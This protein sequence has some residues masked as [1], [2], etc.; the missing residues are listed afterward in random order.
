MHIDIFDEIEY[1]AFD[2]FRYQFLK[3]DVAGDAIKGFTKVHKTGLQFFTFFV[4]IIFDKIM[5]YKMCIWRPIP[6]YKS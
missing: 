1:F 2:S 3:Q 6:W 5:Q 4:T